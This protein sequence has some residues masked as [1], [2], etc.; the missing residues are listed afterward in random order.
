MESV[1]SDNSPKNDSNEQNNK[2][3]DLPFPE[4]NP[5]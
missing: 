4:L 5:K 1:C 2:L 3:A